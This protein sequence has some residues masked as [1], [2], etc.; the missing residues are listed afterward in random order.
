METSAPHVVVRG[1]ARD[2]LQEISAGSHQLK[3]DE[4]ASAGGG[5]AGPDPYDYL[6]AGLGACTSMTVGLHARRRKFPLE[7]ITVGYSLFAAAAPEGTGT[8]FITNRECRE[9]TLAP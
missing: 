2:F 7:K 9:K 1:T 6:M 4:P 5:D 8:E 3:A